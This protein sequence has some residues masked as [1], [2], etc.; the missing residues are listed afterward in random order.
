M[1]R[2][3]DAHNFGVPVPMLNALFWGVADFTSCYDNGGSAP[4]PY[5]T[6]RRTCVCT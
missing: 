1:L 3:V 4:C 5:W 6:G 2:E